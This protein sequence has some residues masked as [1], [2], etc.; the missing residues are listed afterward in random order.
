ML[1]SSRVARERCRELHLQTPREGAEGS[2]QEVLAFGRLASG[3]RL[4]DLPPQIDWNGML[5]RQRRKRG[6]NFV[7]MQRHERF[8]DGATSSNVSSGIHQRLREPRLQ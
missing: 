4:G 3:D 6:Q 7:W 2:V 5:A 8:R 1:R